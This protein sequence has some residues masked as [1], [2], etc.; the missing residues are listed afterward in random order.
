MSSLVLDT[1]ILIYMLQGQEAV[2]EKVESPEV[3]VLI[4]RP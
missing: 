4:F 2:R 3:E 1:N